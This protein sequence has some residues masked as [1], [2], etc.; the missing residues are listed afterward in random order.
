MNDLKDIDV[1]SY[2]MVSL[3][4]VSLFTNIPL[5]KT[6]DICCSRLY[7]DNRYTHCTPNI[8]E[9]VFRNMLLRATS[10]NTFVFNGKLYTQT[11]GVAMGSPLGPVLADVYLSELE[12]TMS[13]HNM[14]PIFYRRF[15]DDTFC[16]FNS[17]EDAELFLQFINNIDPS[18]KFTLEGEVDGKLEFLD[19]VIYNNHVDENGNTLNS[20][21]IFDTRERA[22]NKGLY[23][24]F[25]SCTP[26][27]YKIGLIKSL[28]NTAIQVCSTWTLF[29]LEVNRLSK[30]FQRNGFPLY[31]IQRCVKTAI[32]KFVSKDTTAQGNN[33]SSLPNKYY[34]LSLPYLGECSIQLQKQIYKLVALAYPNYKLRIIFKKQFCIK[35]MFCYKDVLPVSCESWC[36]YSAQCDSCSAVYIG[37]TMNLLHQRFFKS[38]EGHLYKNNRKSVLLD[39]MCSNKGHKFIF[40]DVKVL[41]RSPNCDMTLKVKESLLIENRKPSL[42][43]KTSVPLILF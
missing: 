10:E 37:K 8:P 12:D 18:I 19:T 15:V 2:V 27:V 21:P 9:E 41:A 25:D 16:L 34:N 38:P 43:T 24:H 3:D 42:T 20:K 1:S 29:D 13:N 11:D 35:D 40:D 5:H 39:H 33:D 23:F 4:V 22:T 7:H 28:L 26:L 36:V 17:M 30:V 6:I 14:F 31:I 32:D